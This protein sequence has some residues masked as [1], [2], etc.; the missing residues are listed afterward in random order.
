MRSG[1]TTDAPKTKSDLIKIMSD[2]NQIM[3]DIFLTI[4]HLVFRGLN[5]VLR[6]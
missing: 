5:V 4:S 6:V 2:I 3:S 1:F